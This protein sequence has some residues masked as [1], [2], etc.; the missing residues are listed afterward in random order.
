MKA[1]NFLFCWADSSKLTADK[2][3][4]RTRLACDLR[5]FRKDSNVT[6][7]RYKSVNQTVFYVQNSVANVAAYF[8]MRTVA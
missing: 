8:V 7:K 3:M 1:N 5:A 6:I 2:A 4:T